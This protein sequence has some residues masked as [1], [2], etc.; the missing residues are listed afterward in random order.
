MKNV[1]RNIINEEFKQVMSNKYSQN[2]VSDAILKKH[3]IHTKDGRVFSPVKFDKDYVVGVNDDCEHVNISLDEITM[4][5][6]KEDRF[7]K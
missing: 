5:Q 6:S 3:F 7:G 4:I 2:E 1:L